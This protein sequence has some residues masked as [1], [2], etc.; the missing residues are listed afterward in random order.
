ML[1][2]VWGEH[3]NLVLACVDFFD[4]VDV[5]AALL[6]AHKQNVTGAWLPSQVT[7]GSMSVV[8][9]VVRRVYP[10][11]LSGGDVSIDGDLLYFG[12]RLLDWGERRWERESVNMF[13]CTRVKNM[14]RSR[15]IC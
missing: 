8:D 6:V 12:C 11:D 1:A 2:E 4:A 13:Y 10:L 7:D 14:C 9:H 3:H 5:V 15:W